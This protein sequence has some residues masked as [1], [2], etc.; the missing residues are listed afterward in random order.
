MIEFKS[1]HDAHCC[2]VHGCKYGEHNTCPVCLGVEEG[3]EC[4]E[5]EVVYVDEN[6]KEAYSMQNVKEQ[7]KEMINN[8]KYPFRLKKEE[9]QFAKD[10]GFIVVYGASDDLMEVEG[11]SDEEFGCWEG[12][13][14]LF[15]HEGVLP[16][17]GN[18][19]EDDDEA[20]L[21]FLTRKKN[22][23]KVSQIWDEDGYSWIF[24]TEIPHITF[25]ILK[26]DDKFCRGIIFSIH[27]EW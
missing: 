6:L 27:D 5:C 8:R 1:V 10:N 24:T 22:A 23:K 13:C 21:C 9:K 12:C 19:D 26:C 2:K 7:L 11:Y 14:A 25:D 15:D 18:I 3:I 17:R 4:E 20:L 16:D